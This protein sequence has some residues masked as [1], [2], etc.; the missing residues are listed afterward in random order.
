MSG[1]SN[2]LF[3]NFIVCCLIGVNLNICGLLAFMVDFEV[4]T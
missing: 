1:N 4:F 2:F 3:V